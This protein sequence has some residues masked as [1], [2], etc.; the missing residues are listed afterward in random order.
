M[1]TRP[2]TTKSEISGQG[3]PT[4]VVTGRVVFFFRKG[5]TAFPIK[6]NKNFNH[7]TIMSKTVKLLPNVNNMDFCGRIV[8]EPN[9]SS[10]GNV[11]RFSVIRN[12]G[13]GKS[14]VTIDYVYY[15]PKKGFPD[16]LKKGKAVIVHSYVTPNKWVDKDDVE[17]EEV[18][19]VV[20]SIEEAVLVEKQVKE[21]APAL[22]ED[23]G[24]EAIE[25]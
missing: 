16:L 17:H 24:E 6:R 2:D 8:Y 18:I 19:K 22:S 5:L 12:F 23:S 1:T 20:K 21:N 25:A 7:I 14:P 15:K 3:R 10:N 11:C 9:F 13:G 4:G